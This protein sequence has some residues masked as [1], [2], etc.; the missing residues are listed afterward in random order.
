M[1]DTHGGWDWR[2][3]LSLLEDLDSRDIESRCLYTWPQFGFISWEFQKWLNLLQNCMSSRL[4]AML[5]IT[6]NIYGFPCTRH[7]SEHLLEKLFLICT[8][9]LWHWFS[10]TLPRRKWTHWEGSNIKYHQANEWWSENGEPDLLTWGPVFSTQG[11]ATI[12]KMIEIVYWKILYSV[13]KWKWVL[14]D[15]REAGFLQF[16][17]AF[18]QN[19]M[20][21]WM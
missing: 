6:A 7:N 17:A 3:S 1:N 11:K 4:I 2:G 14:K 13:W 16:V 8:P 10:L 18:S 5:I 21:P 20:V 9:L 12:S 15:F 19:Q